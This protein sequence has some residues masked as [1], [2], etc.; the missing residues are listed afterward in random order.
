[1]WCRRGRSKQPILEKAVAFDNRLAV[2]Y[3]VENK[4]QDVNHISEG[5]STPL[6]V[7]VKKIVKI[8]VPFTEGNWGG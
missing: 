5:G 8:C 4:I 7:A 1:M 6:I 2:D 3:I